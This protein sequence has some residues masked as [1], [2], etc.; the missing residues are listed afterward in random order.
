MDKIA[1]LKGL[2][3]GQGVDPASNEGKVFYAVCDALDGVLKYVEELEDRVAELEELCDILDADLG[4][5]EDDL[6]E[7]DDDEDEDEDPCDL[8]PGG[9]GDIF[10]EDQYETVCPECGETFV[11]DEATLEEGE[12]VCPKCGQELILDFDDEEMD[13]LIPADDSD[14]D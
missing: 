7:D 8:C 3:D 1:Y 5:L 13:E 14:E 9:C 10:D 6:Y 11:L 4:D 2:L 12:T